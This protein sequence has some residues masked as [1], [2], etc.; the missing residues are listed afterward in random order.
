MNPISKVDNVNQ[1]IL[2]NVKPM[3]RRVCVE[4]TNEFPAIDKIFESASKKDITLV[5]MQYEKNPELYND[6]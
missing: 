1:F 6:Y 3:I 4:I 5:S 2:G